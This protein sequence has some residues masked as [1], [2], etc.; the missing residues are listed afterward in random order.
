MSHDASA[1]ST[2]IPDSTRALPS[3]SP[4]TPAP[5][6]ASSSSSRHLSRVILRTALQKANSAVLCDSSNDVAGAI[7]AY[8]EAIT[9]LNRVLETVEKDNDRRRLQEIH[10]SYSER[11][12]LLTALSP[13]SEGDDPYETL[14]EDLPDDAKTSWLA[15]PAKRKYSRGNVRPSHIR[16]TTSTSSI[17]SLI[18]IDL[19]NSHDLTLISPPPSARSGRTFGF[20][21]M[22]QRVPAQPPPG[23]IQPSKSTPV[24]TRSMV[25]RKTKRCSNGYT[26]LHETPRARQGSVVS[27]LTLNQQNNRSSTSSTSS[28]S[29]LSSAED[30]TPK[31]KPSTVQPT[32]ALPSLVPAKNATSAVKNE[33][34]EEGE[35]GEEGE[36][37][38]EDNDDEEDEEEEEAE[39]KP[40]VAIRIRTSSLPKLNLIRP[41]SPATTP[42]REAAATRRTMTPVPQPKQQPQQPEPRPS[43]IRQGSGLGSMRKKANRLSRSSLDGLVRKEKG[44]PIFGLFMKDTMSPRSTASSSSSI[45]YFCTRHNSTTSSPLA[46]SQHLQLILSLERSM[47]HGGYIT[48]RLYIPKSIWHQPNIRLPSMDAKM[49]ACETLIMDLS[50]LEKWTT[51][52]DVVES[53]RLVQVLE[54]A[55][56]VLQTNMSKK[57]KRE[58]MVDHSSPTQYAHETKKGQTF[59]SWGNKLTKSVER[60]NAFSLTKA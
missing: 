23:A 43:M 14:N 45:D 27:A 2:L 44:Q 35:E 32:M 54:D 42:D 22:G 55:V 50:R 19:K 57:L 40:Q 15:K 16:R 5:Q 33:E 25:E 3:S 49:A 12:R 17:D 37:E 24:Q 30:E 4:P 13:K 51:L 6:Q 11:I 29:S 18:S 47:A 38:E 48:Q 34:P 26:D 52:E 20:A 46:T 7:D 53:L 41:N 58:S 28:S 8:T 21:R 36:D 1:L 39:S 60:M 31:T 10:D 9:L 56:E 59:M